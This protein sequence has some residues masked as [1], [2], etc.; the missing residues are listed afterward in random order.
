VRLYRD[1]VTP[2]T[3]F[4][5]AFRRAA[6]AGAS[7]FFRKRYRL[8]LDLRTMDGGTAGSAN[9]HTVR[10]DVIRLTRWNITLGVRGTQYTNDMLEGSLYS[11]RAGTDLGG[12][13]RLELSGG[14]REE[15]NLVTIPLD[16]RVQWIDLDLELDLG[17]H[18]Y[19]LLSGER[20]DGDLEQI[21]QIY[22]SL[23]FHF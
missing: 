3:E 7:L 19:W 22:T 23:N 9:S 16:N 17:Q 10:F 21:D 15:E 13:V 11:L 8:G 12:R 20:T 2:E 5:D 14:V 18:W 1:Q 4:D 6:S